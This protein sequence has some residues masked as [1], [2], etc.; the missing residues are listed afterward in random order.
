M[1]PGKKTF[2]RPVEE[3]DLDS[4]YRWY[5]DPEVNHWANASWPLATL[6]SRD[7]IAERVLSQ[8]DPDFNPHEHYRYLILNEQGNGIGY[9]GFREINVPARSA[10]IFISIGEKTYWGKGYGPD[11]LHTL[12]QFLFRQ[13]NFHRIALDTWDGN[14][15]A[16]RAYEKVGF[17]LEG[18]L[19]EARYVLGKYHD[20]LL[21]SILQPEFFARD[22]E[23]S[24]DFSV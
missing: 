24:P 10:V 4:L 17:Q 7:A 19:R 5:N 2:L 18:R 12:M 8:A 16:I 3:G 23:F 9:I 21:F 11:A 14:T 20:A 15:R 13:W 6:L 1:L 22:P